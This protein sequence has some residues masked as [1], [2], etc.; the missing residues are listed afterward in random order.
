MGL[1]AQFV[2]R[3]GVMY[4]GRLVE[5]A[6]IARHHHRAAASLHAAADRQPAVAGAQGRRCAA[7]PGWRRCCAICRRAARSIRAVRRRWSAAARRSR[8]V[9]PIGDGRHRGV[10]SRMTPLIELRDVTK[11]SLAACCGRER[12]LRSSASRFAIDADAPRDHRRGRRKRQRQ[13]HAGAAAAGPDRSRRRR[14]AVSTGTI[15]A[16]CRRRDGA[17]SAAT[18]RRSSRTRT[19]STTRSIASTTC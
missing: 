3:L 5:V 12:Q 17:T 9:R 8:P 13:D 15:C 4:A 7:F 6:P 11:T 1:M 18:C 2:D 14:G 10:P 19:R 16:A